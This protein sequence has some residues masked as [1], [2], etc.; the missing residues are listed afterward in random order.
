MGI[1]WPGRRQ[2]GHH[3]PRGEK[4]RATTEDEVE[5]LTPKK[6]APIVVRIYIN[7]HMT[8]ECRRKIQ[9]TSAYIY[10]TL[11]KRGVNHDITI[12]A[13][14]MSLHFPSLTEPTDAAGFLMFAGK[15]WKLHRI[16][17]CQVE[18]T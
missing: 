5:E 2:A 14:G 8:H 4:R 9:A 16:Y 15:E 3:S 11:F 13:L 1:S 10:E 12:C 7:L 17:L 6:W 18:W